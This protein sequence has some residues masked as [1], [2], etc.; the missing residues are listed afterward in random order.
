MIVYLIEN[1]INGKKYVGQTVRSLN[2]RLHE[3]IFLDHSVIHRAIDKYGWQNFKVSVLEECSTQEDLN[4][5]EIYYI[6]K[7]DCMTPNGY[8]VVSGGNSTSGYKHTEAHKQR[9]R[10]INSGPKNPRY[11]YACSDKSKRASSRKNSRPV[12]DLTT[13]IEYPS[14][15][16]A[17]EAVGGKI[18][19]ISACANG[20]IK[21]AYGHIFIRL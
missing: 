14:M 10:E 8:N 4:E 15:S 3:H 11:G 17:A 9:L 12:K 21:S 16:A 6:K 19:M 2:R 7:F 18:A 5:R 1:K 20:N 13:G